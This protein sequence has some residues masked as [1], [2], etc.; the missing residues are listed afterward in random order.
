MRKEMFYTKLAEAL[1]REDSAMDSSTSLKGL[2]SLSTMSIIAFVDEHFKARLNARQLS[3]M[4]RV[5]DLMSTIG[6]HHFE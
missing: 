6:E 5:R 4:T 2:D 3:E 1:E